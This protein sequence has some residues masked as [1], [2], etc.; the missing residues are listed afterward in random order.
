M[1]LDKM[2]RYEDDTSETMAIK[3]QDHHAI[4]A[5]NETLYFA[6]YKYKALSKFQNLGIHHKVE[7]RSHKASHPPCKVELELTSVD[8]SFPTDL[9]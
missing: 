7:L 2:K 1:E 8:P 6:F 5:F 3:R 4:I 9:K